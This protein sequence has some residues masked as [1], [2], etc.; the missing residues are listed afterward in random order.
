[1]LAF[2]WCKGKK[3]SNIL[4]Y[5]KLTSNIYEKMIVRLL[6]YSKKSVFCERGNLGLP[7]HLWVRP[8]FH[9]CLIVFTTSDFKHNAI[10]SV[11]FHRYVIVSV[12]FYRS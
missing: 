8:Y 5:R 3:Y 12:S 10:V 6:I 7:G 4:K 11:S 2:L 1:M 9:D